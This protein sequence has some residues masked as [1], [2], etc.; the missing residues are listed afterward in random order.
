MLFLS[1]SREP[2]KPFKSPFLGCTIEE[3]HAIFRGS[4]PGL[5]RNV[6]AKWSSRIFVVLDAATLSGPPTALVA[7]DCSGT[8][9]TIRCDFPTALRFAYCIDGDVLNIAY[10]RAQLV[11]VDGI[12][13]HDLWETLNRNLTTKKRDVVEIEVDRNGERWIELVDANLG[14]LGVVMKEIDVGKGKG[15]SLWK[16][17]DEVEGLMS[18]PPGQIVN[19]LSEN[20]ANIIN[21]KS[22]N[23]IIE[24]L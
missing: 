6:P 5:N 13:T 19:G 18:V 11:D 16:S 23:K 2:T 9:E 15:L 12:V 10:T 1:G 24:K 7:L 8:L 3:I 14:R 20:D 17:K 22:N 4:S 21:G